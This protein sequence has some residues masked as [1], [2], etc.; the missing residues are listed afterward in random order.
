MTETT[1]GIFNR[2]QILLGD[3]GIQRLRNSFVV[4]AGI[5]AVGGYAF[6]GLVRAGVGHIRVVDSDI[7][8]ETDMNRQ[9]LATKETVG[10][11]KVEVARKRA[12]TINPNITVET[13]KAMASA[14]N[15]DE[16]FSGEP[17]YF[18]DAI[19]TVKNKVVILKE[20]VHRNI[21]TF[22]SMG[23][24]LH[25]NTN[26]IKV[27]SL[28]KTK[29][30]PLASLVRSNMRDLDTSNI[31]CVYSEEQI[32]AKPCDKDIYG[33][34]ILGSLPTI[35]AIFGMILAN[36]VIKDATKTHKL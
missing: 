2:T 6:E 8:S 35:P 3:D 21:R 11:F 28:K 22:S 13:I 9:I 7:F 30:C 19:D 32:L 23:A 1:S 15:L 17:N 24:A 31:T 27:S 25:S 20:A 33:K 16:I 26:M 5:G 36:E 4:I 12:K 34:S 10:C 29:V 14:E 18:V